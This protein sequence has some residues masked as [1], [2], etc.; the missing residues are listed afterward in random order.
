MTFQNLFVSSEFVDQ[1]TYLTMEN[2]KMNNIVKTIMDTKDLPSPPGVA[3]RL[4]ELF[5]QDDVELNEVAKVVGADS[6][7]TARLIDFC[8]SPIMA[9][10]SRVASIDQAVVT[11]GM[12]AVK[13]IGL[14]FSL[15]Q[16]IPAESSGFN[17][18]LFWNQSL[19]TAIVGSTFGKQLKADKDAVFL[20]GL[21]L[22]IG[23]MA[24]AHV[25]GAQYLEAIVEAEER[26]VALTEVEIERW[27]IDRYE[28]GGL[29]ME[30]WKFPVE[31][32]E[33]ISTY[34]KQDVEL[35]QNAKILKV[36]EQ[37]SEM[38][39][40]EDVHVDHIE[41]AKSDAMELLG[42]D[43]TLFDELFDESIEVW[44]EY[45]KVF[46]F[47][48]SRATTIEQLES[49][50]RR[51]IAE[52]SLGL[53]VEN[54][55]MKQENLRLQTNIKVDPLTGL[56]NRRAYDMEAN[57]ELERCRNN[58]KPFV[59]MVVDIDHFKNFNDSYGHA[60]GDQVLIGVAETLV[61]HTRG[62]DSV[63]RLG[64]E[65]F[66][67]ILA[68]AS[69]DVGHK[70]AERLRLAVEAMTIDVDDNSHRVTVSIGVEWDQ[71]GKLSLEQVF[72]GADALMYKAKQGGRNRSCT[73]EYMDRT[74]RPPYACLDVT[75]SLNH[76]P[77]R[78]N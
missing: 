48:C 41:K 42:V 39:F 43:S 11:L 68:E 62:Y 31:M 4:L 9:R 27:T 67:V 22:N 38:L 13:M 18:D 26:N 34:S 6:V 50:A 51:E 8:N 2:E 40:N 7:L 77:N 55:K 56:K 29:L 19:A 61:D 60:V 65:E 57:A 21:I 37:V 44:A 70:A 12:R 17:Y 64:G 14:S 71:N 30:K 23:Q 47:D 33:E 53:Q 20:S 49:R 58:K 28:L 35:S 59:M 16:T 52:L 25:A 63:Y 10:N 69:P 75:A 73:S 74:P 1:T 36:A 72:N 54:T 66:V 46:N 3:V 76:V 24:L 15:V 5:G 78:S 32:S 45:T